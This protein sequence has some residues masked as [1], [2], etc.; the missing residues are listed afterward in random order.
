MTLNETLYTL[1]FK[2]EEVTDTSYC[3]IFF[4]IASLEEAFIRNI[5]IIKYINYIIITRIND[6]TAVINN[7]YRILQDLVLL[8]RTP[9]GTRKYFFE[10]YRPFGHAFSKRFAALA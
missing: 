7:N 4:L 3:H 8:F 10:I 2:Q 6:Y 9:K 5:I 1:L